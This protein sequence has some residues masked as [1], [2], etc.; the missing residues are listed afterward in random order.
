[1]SKNKLSL[2][3]INMAGIYI[4]IPFCKQKCSYCAFHF[5]T[6]LSYTERMIKALC[7]EITLRKHELD[8]QE[9][10]TIYFGGGTPS[11]LSEQ[12]LQVIFDTLRHS[13]DLSNVAEITLEANPDDIT[14]EKVL[15]WKALGINR[16]SI[17]IQSFDSVDLQWMN[18]AHT[19]EQSLNSI[20]IA[21]NS[22]IPNITIDLM[23]GLPELSLEK[24]KSTIQQVLALNVPHISAYC[25]TVEERTALYQKVKQQT[26]LPSD[27]DLQNEQFDLLVQTLTD[28]GFL[29]YEI[30]NF[31]KPDFIAVHNTNY[32]NGNH[33]LGI[34][35]SAHSF[36]G[37]CRK[38]NIS[39]NH[40]YMKALENNELPYEIETLTPKN[41]FNELLLTGLRTV[42][43]VSLQ[44]LEEIMPL[45]AEFRQKVKHYTAE[46]LMFEQQ[47][48]LI[49][50]QQGKHLADT[51]AEDL[52]E[53]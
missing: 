33:Y 4:H 48:H 40:T 6:N 49:L 36:D 7:Q 34:G 50:T 10:K 13:F 22:G 28:N 9:I 46:K 1:M 31:G 3:K 24:W 42:W 19:A 43:G 16:L 2:F 51:I 18:R 5:S 23:Y 30:S 20:K 53:V 17:G 27:Q 29:H 52:F 14:E 45:T 39:N 21:Q 26:L 38:W 37:A 35:P 47:N 8:N 25:L 11:I 32:W 41:K 15:L 12:Q 44:Q